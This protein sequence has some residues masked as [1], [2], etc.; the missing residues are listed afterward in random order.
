MI[1]RSAQWQFQSKLAPQ[2]SLILLWSLAGTMIHLMTLD[3]LPLSCQQMARTPHAVKLGQSQQK[4][5]L[6]GE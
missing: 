6:D 2:G 5:D 3:N 1:P 4:C